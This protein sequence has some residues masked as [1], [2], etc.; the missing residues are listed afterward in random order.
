MNLPPNGEF[1]G[2]MSM[3]MAQKV[4]SKTDLEPEAI[5]DLQTT[6]RLITHFSELFAHPGRQPAGFGIVEQR[7]DDNSRRHHVCARGFH[8]R[9]AALVDQSRMLNGAYTQLSPLVR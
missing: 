1:S 8:R 7:S 9:R 4:R 3:E 6:K 2:L 5:H